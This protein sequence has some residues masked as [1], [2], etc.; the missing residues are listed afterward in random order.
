MARANDCKLCLSIS[1][2]GMHNSSRSQPSL[3]RGSTLPMYF[4]RLEN[5]AV[6]FQLQVNQPLYYALFFRF[7]FLVASHKSRCLKC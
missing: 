7:F 2:T 4:T 3:F 6:L 1:P 5:D